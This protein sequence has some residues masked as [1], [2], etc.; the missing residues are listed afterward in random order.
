MGGQKYDIYAEKA[1]QFYRLYN[2]EKENP[3]TKEAGHIAMREL[4]EAAV[5]LVGLGDFR[6]KVSD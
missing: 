1:R 2:T 3:P 6:G 4:E 5:E